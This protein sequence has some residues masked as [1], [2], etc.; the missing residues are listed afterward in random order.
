MAKT[1][2]RPGIEGSTVA[3]CR[4]SFAL[5][6]QEHCKPCLDDAATKVY[7]SYLEVARAS[8][9]LEPLTVSELE[10][11]HYAA[12]RDDLERWTVAWNLQAPWMKD[13]LLASFEAWSADSKRLEARTLTPSIEEISFGPLRNRLERRL[14]LSFDGWDPAWESY[15]EF[16]S[17][18]MDRFKQALAEHKREGLQAASKAQADKSRIA[19]E[20]LRLAACYQVLELSYE[21]VAE[22]F[23]RTDSKQVSRDVKKALKIIGLPKRAP[24]R[25]GKRSKL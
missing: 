21:V 6:L 15:S 17:R 7:P 16:E 18:A 14:R 25:G 10:E 20:H 5:A 12:L 11:P 8:Y 24:K 3:G 23:G 13:R 1:Y 19:V 4:G 2:Y 9:R 22:R